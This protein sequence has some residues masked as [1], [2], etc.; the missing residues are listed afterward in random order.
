MYWGA[1]LN[2][3]NASLPQAWFGMYIIVVIIGIIFF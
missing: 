3:K 1:V 2:F